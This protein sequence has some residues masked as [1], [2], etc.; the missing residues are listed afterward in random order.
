MISAPSPTQREQVEKALRER[1]RLYRHYRA[2]KRSYRQN[3]YA[4]HPMGWRLKAFASHLA[5]FK[6]PDAAAFLTYVMEENRSWLLTAP[7]ELRAEAKTLVNE[8]IMRIREAH[9]LLPLDDPLP[10]GEEEDSIWL[11]CRQELS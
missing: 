10:W 2:A 4:E 6:M 7:P 11:L 9:G 5:R 3:L 8:R 1:D